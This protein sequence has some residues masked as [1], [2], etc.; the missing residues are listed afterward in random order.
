[1]DVSILIVNYNTADLISSCLNSILQ[2]E[3]ITYEIIVV[4]NRSEDESLQ[5]LKDY[6]KQITLIANKDNKGFGRANNQAA[7]IAKGNFLFFLNPDA[8]LKTTDDLENLVNYFEKNAY[9]LVGTRIV[10][11]EEQVELTAFDHYPHQS[12]THGDFRSLPGDIASVL[13]ASM[14]MRRSVFEEL[15]GFDEDYFLYTEETDL[16]LRVRK[17]GYAIGYCNEVTV[18][19]IGSASE[20]KTPPLEVIRKKKLGKYL[21]YRKHYPARDVLAIAKRDLGNARRKCWILRITKSLIGLTESQQLA[22]QQQV[23]LMELAY[24]LKL[25]CKQKKPITTKTPFRAF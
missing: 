6:E 12:E 16:C 18:Q 14:F 23:M 1:M 20:R 11:R 19:H 7:R 8:T 22:L 25:E 5:V 13:G 3:G 10:N 17:A 21:F 9:G 4:D 2:Q 24:S 15:N